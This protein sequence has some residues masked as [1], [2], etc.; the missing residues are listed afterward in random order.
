M[1][2]FAHNFSIGASINPG[3]AL[4]LQNPLTLDELRHYAPSAFATEPH[5]SRS[6]RYT[7]IPT[8]EVIAGLMRE[9]FQPFKATQGRSRVAGKAEY[10]K[11]LIRFR[12]PDSFNAIQ[13]VGDSVPEVVL[14]NSHDG[15]SA[16]KLSAGLFRLVCSNGLMVSDSTVPMLSI[17]HKGDIVRD[18]IEGSFQIVGQSEKA[19]ARA[20]EWNQLQLTAGEQGAFAEAAR[21]LRFADVEG[22]IKTP[23]TA[24]QLLR[25]RRNEDADGPV[26]WRRPAAPKPDL[27]HTL[28]V[29]QENTV[30]GGLHGTQ[31][32]TD[33]QTGRRTMR[34]VTTRE[35][36]GIDQDVKLNRAL[37]ML[38]ERMAELK[39]AAVA[40]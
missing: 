40:A 23:I 15:T 19:L 3:V 34:R 27:W 5:E 14:V 31:R 36:R 6:A 18:V 17:Q 8:S 35:V 12:H 1:N 11:H 24:E 37:W 13:K 39:G 32:G 22:Q 29:V 33:P 10:T 2:N 38:A 25:P 21:E 20:D 16:Y 28:N 4:R 7:Y 9:G 30:R 26:D